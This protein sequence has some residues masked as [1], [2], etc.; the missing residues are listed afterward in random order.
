VLVLIR[1]R[2]FCLVCIQLLFTHLCT[3]YDFLYAAQLFVTAVVLVTEAG[4]SMSASLAV[5]I[6][7]ADLIKAAVSAAVAGTMEDCSRCLG[8]KT[9]VA[10]VVSAVETL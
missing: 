2:F 7:M 9:L 3:H 10:A 8:R 1:S 5:A 4:V 6:S